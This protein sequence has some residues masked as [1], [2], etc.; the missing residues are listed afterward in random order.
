MR[1]HDCR[2]SEDDFGDN[3]TVNT[4]SKASIHAGMGSDLMALCGK[5]GGCAGHDQVRLSYVAE[6][7]TCPDCL[8]SRCESLQHDYDV[9][10]KNYRQR[11]DEEQRQAEQIARLREALQGVMA[12]LEY[13]LDPQLYSDGRHKAAHDKA[14]A[15]LEE[16]QP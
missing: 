9:L 1:T 5:V 13:E 10:Y 4:V 8:K 11:D 2:E 7:V 12:S 14:R 6:Q 3:K 15:I 16:T